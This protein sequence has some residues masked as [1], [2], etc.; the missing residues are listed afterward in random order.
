MWGRSQ[1]VLWLSQSREFRLN[2]CY[3]MWKC[4]EVDE[5]IISPE[6]REGGLG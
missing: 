6:S 2:E 5:V 1:S 4:F 3:R